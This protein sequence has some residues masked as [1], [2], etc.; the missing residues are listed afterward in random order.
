MTK[1]DT[2]K[3][4]TNIKVSPLENS[5]VELEGEIE[6][7]V[8]ELH[9]ARALKSILENAEIPGFRKGTAPQ[10]LVLQHYSEARIL[11]TAAHEAL[12]AEYWNILTDNSIKA[13][14][15]PQVTITKLA[16]GNPLGFKIKTAVFPEVI[17]P[18][19][20]K[21]ASG[22]V[23]EK[24]ED[25]T[26]EQ[27][28]VDDVL[29]QLQHAKLH[30]KEHA[31]G[32]AHG[33][34]DAH[35]GHDHNHDEKDFPA[36]DDAFAQSVAP[37]FKTLAELTEKIRENMLADKKM[38]TKEKR[39]VSIIE[40]LVAETN[41][42][43]PEIL[44]ESEMQKMIAQFKDDI[45]RAGLTYQAYLEHVKKTEADLRTEWKDTA[46]KRAKT[47]LILAKIG[48]EEGL[49]LD[50]EAVTKEIEHIMSHHKDAD[51]FRVRM[52]IENMMQ[53]EKVLAFLEEQ[54]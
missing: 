3:K 38:K 26:V 43:V 44:I 4:Y 34:T 39:R 9:R 29:K 27:K 50:E 19:Y 15:E 11:E 14:G 46:V 12:D 47:Q 23:G 10:N 51:R 7:E 8:L 33:Q 48:K 22:V 21:I 41:V 30:E 40:A 13:I 49:K 36:L 42:E 28:E 37:E 45:A 20:K 16:Q 24:V 6:A 2:S 25:I 1:K 52:F 5:Q 31:A 17:L 53:N 18:N 32:H 54:K 35:E